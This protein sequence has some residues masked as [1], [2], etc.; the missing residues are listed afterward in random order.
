MKEFFFPGKY[1][2]SRAETHF[3]AICQDPISFQ[4][5]PVKGWGTR[6]ACENFYA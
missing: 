1:L 3:A 4:E 2:D 6:T 5:D